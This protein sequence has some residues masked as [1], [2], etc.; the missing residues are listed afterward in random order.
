MNQETKLISF[1]KL[2]ANFFQYDESG[3][4]PFAI[5]IAAAPHPD[6]IVEN[7]ILKI[8]EFWTEYSQQYLGNEIDLSR[9]STTEI[10]YGNSKDTADLTDIKITSNTLIL[11]LSYSE[12]R[13]RLITLEL[14]DNPETFTLH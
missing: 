3:D 14:S 9:I 12:D 4:L 6:F 1:T 13:E 2:E 10:S 8:T 7:T 11:I 5:F